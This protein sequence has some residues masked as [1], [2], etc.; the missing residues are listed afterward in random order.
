MLS[1]MVIMMPIF[2]LPEDLMRLYPGVAPKCFKHYV[3]R[4]CLAN[5]ENGVPKQK[6]YCIFLVD[7]YQL[8]KAGNTMFLS[9][10]YKLFFALCK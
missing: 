8:I 5:V 7:V 9:G 6:N 3:V 2:K 1:E 10:S 4:I